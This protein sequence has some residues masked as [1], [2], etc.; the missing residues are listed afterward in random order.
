MNFLQMRTACAAL[1]GDET[2]SQF[3]AAQ[4]NVYL[5]WGQQE[6]ARRLELLQQVQVATALDSGT[7]SG[8]L[9]LSINFDQEMFVLW[10]NFKLTRMDYASYL[11]GFSPGQ[12]GADQPSYYTI[13]N[14]DSTTGLR[15]M[16]FFP[17]QNFA[18]TGLSIQ[19]V[20]QGLPADMSIDGDN[21]F[22]PL[23]CHEVVVLYAVAR[24][25]MQENDMQGYQMVMR[26]VDMR[27][28]SLATLVEESDAFSYSVIRS[29]YDTSWPVILDG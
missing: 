3:T 27:C 7:L 29:D 4:V 18:R 8:G 1:T 17:Y 28:M 5:N 26:D 19:V 11:E 20:Y 22:L 16:L 24:C 14:A 21:C 23:P 6:V 12:L 2:F 13:Q 15:R 9:V 25:K 10:S